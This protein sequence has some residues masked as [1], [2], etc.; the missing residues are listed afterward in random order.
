MKVTIEFDIEAKTGEEMADK[1]L[2]VLFRQAGA[3]ADV[4]ARAAEQG[5]S[6]GATIYG[7]RFLGTVRAEIE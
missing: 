6:A 3:I 7:P 2:L 1:V 4:A 5:Y